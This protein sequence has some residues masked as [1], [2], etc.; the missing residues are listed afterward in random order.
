VPG[1]YTWDDERTLNLEYET[2]DDVRQAYA[3]AVEAYQKEVK[4]RIQA[5]KLPDRAGPSILGAVSDELPAKETFR[6]G[7]SEQPRLLILG[8]ENGTSQTFEKAD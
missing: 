1:R 8:G 4:D 6:V 5:G 7:L 3:A 2:A